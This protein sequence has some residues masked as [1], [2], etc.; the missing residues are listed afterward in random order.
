ERLEVLV[1]HRP[2]YDDWSWPKGKPRK[3]EMLPACAI[4]EVEEE[5]GL[6]VVLGA[7][8]PRV[9]YRLRSGRR[10]IN[11]YWAAQ[12]ADPGS[13]TEARP[14][15]E[16]APPTEVDGAVWVDAARDLKML[17]RPSDRKPLKALLEL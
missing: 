2:S 7:P 12:V 3:Q 1:I 6:Q 11:W 4:R 8:L 9:T 13:V 16:P 10:K 17:T 14:G 15:V 5:T